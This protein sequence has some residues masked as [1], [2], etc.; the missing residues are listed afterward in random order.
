VSW[1]LRG[2]SDKHKDERE[3]RERVKRDVRFRDRSC[4][5]QD[6]PGRC[7][8][9]LDVHEVIPRSAWRAG[10][11]IRSNCL[12]ICRAH[13]DWI[14]DNPDAAHELGLHGYSWERTDGDV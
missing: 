11:L 9:P 7:E 6:A 1:G 2:E 3:E 12:L 4:R 10:Y 8:G 13:H 14:H 5:A